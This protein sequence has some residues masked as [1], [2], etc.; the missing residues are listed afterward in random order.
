M[1]L[2]RL[3]KVTAVRGQRQDGGAICLRA[4]VDAHPMPHQP[5]PRRGTTA[6]EFGT[7]G[8]D[9]IGRAQGLDSL[10]GA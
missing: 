1:R 7:G 5:P 3:A 10:T 6:G 8:G 9:G 2:P 4:L